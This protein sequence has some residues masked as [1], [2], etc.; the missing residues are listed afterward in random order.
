MNVLVKSYSSNLYH[1]GERDV[2]VYRLRCGRT[3]KSDNAHAQEWP[4]TNVKFCV[5]CG[6]TADYEKV[7]GALAEHQVNQV[8]KKQQHELKMNRQRE[9]LEL[10]NGQRR[11]LAHAIQDALG[12]I[13]ELR[14]VEI[15]YFAAGAEL[16]GK[17]EAD[18]Q[19]HD[20]VLRLNR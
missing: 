8:N 17:F 1:I 12:A 3:I 18:G 19:I 10:R 7:N 4:I 16:T 11:Y 14:G 15:E 5:R 2:S 20:F 9:L 13:A 6:N